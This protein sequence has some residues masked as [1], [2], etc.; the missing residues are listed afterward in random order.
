[1]RTQTIAGLFDGRDLLS[2]PVD[3]TGWLAGP[4]VPAR[5]SDGSPNGSA[6]ASPVGRKDATPTLDV[7]GRLADSR[8][9]V[10][11]G[12]RSAR[13]PGRARHLRRIRTE[14]LRSE[15]V[16][17]EAP[18][19]APAIAPA[20]VQTA[21]EGYRM[22]RWA[23]LALTITV[24]AATVVVVLTLAA[25]SPPRAMVDVTV[26][27]GDTLWSI[28]TQAAPERDPRAVIDE[29]RQLN[30]VPG[31][32]LPIGVVLRVPASAG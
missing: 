8:R 13:R 6:T 26:G 11:P 24:V 29:I 3:P 16:R 30:N 2:T 32:V 19:I 21:T 27:P 4:T 5:G 1:M 7:S 20:V 9:D 31:G 22:G 23:R 10:R 17:A 15:V 14:A 25:G 12:R 18:A 28:A